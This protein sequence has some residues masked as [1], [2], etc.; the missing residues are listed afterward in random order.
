MV[1]STIIKAGCEFEQQG[2]K[3]EFRLDFDATTSYTIT[4]DDGY[5][6]RVTDKTEHIAN[7]DEIEAVLYTP[8]HKKKSQNWHNSR[9]D[10]VEYK[11]YNWFMNIKHISL[12]EGNNLYLLTF[13]RG[14][15]VG[16]GFL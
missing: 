6:V 13:E 15:Q 4:F 2:L 10:E 12:T 1:E 9:I 16:G 11:L 8:N 14:K 5:Y 3:N 7:D